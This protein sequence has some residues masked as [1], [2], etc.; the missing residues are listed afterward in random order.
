MRPG[1]VG[2]LPALFTQS[3]VLTRGHVLKGAPPHWM[4]K[5]ATL[6]KD[7]GEAP[8]IDP[9]TLYQVAVA[10]TMDLEKQRK[11]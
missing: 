9:G 11:G 8:P 4:P 10:V 3:P 6:G 1:T 7:G 2:E 5:W